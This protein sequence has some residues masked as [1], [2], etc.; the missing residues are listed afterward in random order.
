MRLAAL[1]ATFSLAAPAVAGDLSLAQPVDCV[2]GETCFIQQYVD[3]D[4]GPGAQDFTCGPLSYQG[5][6]GTD[7]GLPSFKAMRNGVDV[8]AAAPGV[9]LGMRNGMD[10]IGFSEGIAQA[11]SG[12]ECGNGVVLDHGDGWQTQYCHMKKGSVTVNTGQKV[13]TGEVLGQIGFSGKTEFP[14]LHLSVRKDGKVVDPFDPDGRITCGI[15]DSEQLWQAPVEYT[16]GGFLSAGFSDAVPSYDAV[17]DGTVPTPDSAAAPALVLW[18]YAYGARAGDHLDMRITGPDGQFFANTA[19]MERNK[20]QFFRAAGRR[21]PA[22]GL[23]RGTY[24]GTVSLL[25]DGV[26]VDVI[27]TEVTLR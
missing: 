19:E 3:H 13:E 27:Q 15:P 25:R 24:S 16:P 2:L 5:H 26:V 17:K 1:I 14:H 10:D 4:P 23:A 21:S 22:G 7:F 18:Y 20:A 6:K 12:R 11:V 8:L 9:V